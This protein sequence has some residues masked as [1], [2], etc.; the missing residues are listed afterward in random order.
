MT[1]G[2]GR[3]PAILVRE[4]ARAPDQRMDRLI[5][6]SRYLRIQPSMYADAILI[7]VVRQQALEKHTVGCRHGVEE[8]PI[9]QRA[10]THVQRESGLR[11]GRAQGLRSL[12]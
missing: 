4:A 8:Q 1:I 10:P 6:K 5:L 9:R 2:D 7:L 12:S 3:R 11:H